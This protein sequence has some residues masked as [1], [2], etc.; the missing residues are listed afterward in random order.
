ME[1]AEHGDRGRRGPTTSIRDRADPETHGDTLGTARAHFFFGVLGVLGADRPVFA[2][3]RRWAT[4]AAR[5]PCVLKKR[6]RASLELC[7]RRASTSRELGVPRYGGRTHAFWA[8]IKQNTPT[9]SAMVHSFSGTFAE[10]RD[11]HLEAASP[12]SP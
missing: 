5:D 11:E 3:L 12:A 7:A 2:A 1:Q 10:D 6:T 9:N 4:T 8:H